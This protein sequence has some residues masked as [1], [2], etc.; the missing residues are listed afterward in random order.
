M[1]LLGNKKD[2]KNAKKADAKVAA[3]PK[4]VDAKAQKVEKKPV[5]SKPTEKKV[6]DKK[7]AAQ[8]V[9]KKAAPAPKATAKAAPAAKT[10]AKAAPAPAKATKV[11]ATSKNG[12][13]IIRKATANFVFALQAANYETIA[14]S[15]SGYKSLDAAKAGVES[16]KRFLNSPVQD[17]TLKKVEDVKNPKYEIYLDKAEKYRFRLKANNGEIILVSDAYSSKS[18]CQNGIKSIQNHAPFADVEVLKPEKGTK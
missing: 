15:G 8:K 3:Q 14:T 2:A 18:S 17:L 10:T 5:A 13:F 7:P 12:K 16:T 6:A 1:G 9:D 4:K 11:A